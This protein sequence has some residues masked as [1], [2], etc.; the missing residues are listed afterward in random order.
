M[1]PST[2]KSRA[3]GELVSS[4][5]INGA[6]SLDQI[7]GDLGHKIDSSRDYLLVQFSILSYFFI[8]IRTIQQSLQLLPIGRIQ[9]R[10]HCWQLCC[11]QLS[12]KLQI[13]CP[14]KA[15]A[16]TNDWWMYLYGHRPILNPI[17]V[18]YPSVTLRFGL[19]LRLIISD[20]L[21]AVLIFKLVK[22]TAYAHE[23]HPRNAYENQIGNT[24]SL[25]TQCSNIARSPCT[26]PRLP[27]FSLPTLPP[28]GSHQHSLA[29]GII[30][31]TPL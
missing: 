21:K 29:C 7:D 2:S 8:K 22:S 18:I 28:Y 14:W 26:W 27:V 30:I 24:S 17:I 9:C 4:E 31:T 23:A 1:D 25:S 6:F 19:P 12:W 15:N 10:R 16:T 20:P 11:C 3:R 5:R 13:R